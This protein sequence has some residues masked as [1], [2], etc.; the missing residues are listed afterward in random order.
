MRSLEL[1]LDYCK[2][3]SGVLLSVPAVG[4]VVG[5]PAFDRCFGTEF[6]NFAFATRSSS[7]IV[8]NP[9]HCSCVV[10]AQ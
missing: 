2:V 8:L 6:S 7:V 9:H 1:F 3:E 4:V 5:R 10:I